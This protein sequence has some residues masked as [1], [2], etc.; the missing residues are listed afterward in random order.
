MFYLKGLPHKLRTQMSRFSIVVVSSFCSRKFLSRR[1]M[2]GTSEERPETYQG[3]DKE[4]IFH[5]WTETLIPY[6][7]L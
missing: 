7:F 2:T 6:M 1:M 5:C 3:T 4:Y